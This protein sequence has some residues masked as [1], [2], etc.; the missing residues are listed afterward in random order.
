TLWMLDVNATGTAEKPSVV[1]VSMCRNVTVAPD[2]GAPD[3]ASAM[4]PRVHPEAAIA[5]HAPQ[6]ARISV[7]PITYSPSYIDDMERYAAI[8]TTHTCNGTAPAEAMIASSGRY[9]AARPPV[10]R[11]RRACAAAATPSAA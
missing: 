2:S 9:G 8:H 10:P 1:E 4:V 7:F 3:I 5:T 11:S 6:A